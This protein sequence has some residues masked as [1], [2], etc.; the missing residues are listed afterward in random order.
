MITVV[1]VTLHEIT[2]KYACFLPTPRNRRSVGPIVFNNIRLVVE[3]ALFLPRFKHLGRTQ[4]QPPYTI[5]N[6]PEQIN[7]PNQELKFLIK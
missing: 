5:I 4:I 7:A 6:T 2:N 3:F 1:E